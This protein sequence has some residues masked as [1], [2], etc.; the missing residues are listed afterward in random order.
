MHLYVRCRELLNGSREVSGVSGL[1]NG[2]IPIEAS[3][4][5]GAEVYKTALK[6]SPL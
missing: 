6:R 1:S 4:L 3:A 5:S 2:M